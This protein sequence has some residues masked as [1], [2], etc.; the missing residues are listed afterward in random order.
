MKDWLARLLGA[1]TLERLADDTV[2]ALRARGLA[3]IRVDLARA[4]IRATQDGGAVLLNLGNLHAGWRRV[5]RRERAAVLERFLASLDQAGRSPGKDT[6]WAEARVRLLP[7]LRS[8][9]TLGL[10]ALARGDATPGVRDVP[11]RPFAGAVVIV[12]VRD[13]PDSMAYVTQDLLDAWQV[14]FDEALAA[15]LDNLR[16][17]PGDGGW[18]ALGDGLWSGAWDDAYEPSRLLLP[19][20]VHRL[21]VARPVAMAPFGNVLLVTGAHNAAGLARLAHVAREARADLTRQV[22][23]ELFRLDERRW[24]S[25]EPPPGPTA[26]VLAELVSEQRG[27]DYAEQKKLLDEAFEGSGEDVTVASC[28]GLRE[29]GGPLRTWAVW[30]DGI[31]TLLPATDFVAFAWKVDEANR[32]VLVPWADALRLAGA[33]MQPTGHVPPR[34]R[35][36]AFPDAALL[37]ELERHAAA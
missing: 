12:L 3:D 7:V 14:G 19:D 9:S 22:S 36:Q 28:I 4:E 35:V 1:P 17:L 20:L 33:L 25:F 21:G 15:A 27:A 30:A 34:W 8:A 2:R 16:E 5:P 23:F 13:M 26:D 29:D 37:A 10:S 18:Q 32:H 11:S 6:P 31:D 24:L